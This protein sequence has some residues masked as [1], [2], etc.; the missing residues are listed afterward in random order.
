MRLLQSL[1]L[2]LVGLA[3]SVAAQDESLTIELDKSSFNKFIKENDVV[4]TDC[5]C[6]FCVVSAPYNQ[7]VTC[8]V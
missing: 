8:D 3:A 1:A 2:A 6:Y 5:E 4:M 7:R